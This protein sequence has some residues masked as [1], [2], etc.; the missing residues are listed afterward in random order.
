MRNDKESMRL[1]DGGTEREIPR[2]PRAPRCPSFLGPVAKAEWRRLA[3]DL[4]SRGFL[5]S[6]DRGVFVIYCLAWEH[7]VQAQEL[8]AQHGLVSEVE[9]GSYEPS[10]YFGVLNTATEM[11]IESADRMGLTPASR[12]RIESAGRATRG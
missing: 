11:L 7:V 5:T 4:A 10:P 6:L 2:K 3:G 9:D 1:V 12:A 8:V